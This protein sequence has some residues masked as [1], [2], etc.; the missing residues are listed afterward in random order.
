MVVGILLSPRN[1]LLKGAPLKP[2]VPCTRLQVV[3]EL[4]ELRRARNMWAVTKFA[5]DVVVV[6]DVKPAEDN[7][8]I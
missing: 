3:H 2:K 1:N 7:I 6:W 8:S 5:L 4:R